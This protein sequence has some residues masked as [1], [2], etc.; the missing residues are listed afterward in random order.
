VAG[1]ARDAEDGSVAIL[2]RGRAH[3]D[4][5]VPA[6]KAAGVRFRAVDIEPLRRRPVIQDLMAIARALSHL[7]DRVAWLALLRAPW[8]ALTM[9]DMHALLEGAP[10]E[11]DLT[12][13]ELLANPERLARLGAEGAS[14]ALRVRDALAPFVEGRAR[15]ALRSRVE[16]AWLALGGPACVERASDLEDAETFF[17]RL[18]ELDE[19]GDLADPTQ[20]QDHLE[21]LFAAP[22]VGEE[23]RVQVMT[24]HRA[25]GL[26]FD[27]VIV[28]GM[29]RVPRVSDRPLFHWKARADGSLMM[30]PMRRTGETEEPAYDYLRRLDIDASDHEIERVLYV[31]ATR[32]RKRLHLLGFAR[33]KPNGELNPPS[34]TKSLLGKAWEVAK[35]LFEAAT[36]IAQAGAV[37]LSYRQSLRTLD[38]A[39]LAVDVPAPPAVPIAAPDPE[40]P[41]RF[42]WA[43]ETARHVGTVT[44][45]W[46]QRVGIEGVDAWDAKRVTALAPAIE[47]DLE[48]RGI[49]RAEREAAKARV[50]KALTAGVTDKRGRWILG[51][52]PESRF[53]YRMRVATPE[54]VRLFVMDRLFTDESG[55]RWIVDYKTSTHEGGAMEAFLDSELERYAPQLARY[56]GAFPDAPST[57][58]L[59]FPLVQGWRELEP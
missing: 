19:A 4:R 16:S 58:A 25:K 53:E 30:A 51:P 45:R 48:R 38:L 7:A 5:I 26:E 14:R 1:L 35:P 22:D 33:I 37:D 6:L 23:A 50:A 39:A 44:H 24:I 49:P 42:D 9:A 29:E 27:T 52:H 59:Y 46:L 40:V 3:L 17:N 41:L 43:S 57:A 54:G 28:P 15:G 36:P 21:Q 20:L 31:A 56:R 12:A 8:C 11:A 13:W 47:R 18:E 2:V 55:R 34:A 10:D 32:A